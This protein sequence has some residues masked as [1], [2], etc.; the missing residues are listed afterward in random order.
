MPKG[1]ILSK[2]REREREK[3][4]VVIHL[5]RECM[6]V[7]HLF[8]V[9]IDVFSHELDLFL[10]NTTFNRVFRR[11]ALKIGKHHIYRQISASV[12]QVR[13]LRHLDFRNDCWLIKASVTPCFSSRLYGIRH[14]FKTNGDSAYPLDIFILISPNFYELYINMIFINLMLVTSTYIKVTEI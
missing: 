4:L 13:Y 8:S 12:R 3:S 9:S 5:V 6:M 1:N 14:C 10:S 11:F 7:I 2:M